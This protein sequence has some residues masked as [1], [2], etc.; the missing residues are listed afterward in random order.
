MSSLGNYGEKYI[1]MKLHKKRADNLFKPIIQI[2]CMLIITYITLGTSYNL[3]S[4]IWGYR[5]LGIRGAHI[6]S[7]YNFKGIQE[8]IN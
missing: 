3:H 8:K 5:G 4:V 7:F 6:I 1:T 2:G